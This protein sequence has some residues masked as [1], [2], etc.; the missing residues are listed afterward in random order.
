MQI[1]YK[2]MSAPSQS[3]A[4]LLQPSYKANLLG[5]LETAEISLG[6]LSN[7]L[8]DYLVY[9]DGQIEKI[10]REHLIINQDQNLSDS[11]KNLKKRQ[12]EKQAKN[13]TLPIATKNF[14]N[15][16][17]IFFSLSTLQKKVTSSIKD[18]LENLTELTQTK[19]HD[20]QKAM[21]RERLKILH[22]ID[23]SFIAYRFS[24]ITQKMKTSKNLF[25]H[26][27]NLCQEGGLSSQKIDK[28]KGIIT[29]TVPGGETIGPAIA[30]VLTYAKDSIA[31]L[32]AFTQ[33]NSKSHENTY[34][35]EEESKQY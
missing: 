35:D 9:I 5:E 17:K 23:D 13:E 1:W 27:S 8:D 14:L 32:S 2:I 22:A 19:A 25:D 16:D 10:K 18:D 28:F 12:I 15:L 3:S 7:G 29:N 24:Q 34:Y 21:H 4:I 20:Q 33:L 30:S 31:Y 11:E 6:S 26:F